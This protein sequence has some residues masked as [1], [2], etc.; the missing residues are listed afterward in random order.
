MPVHDDISQTNK[1]TPADSAQ[2]F[3]DLTPHRP[4]WL[5]SVMVPGLV[6]RLVLGMLLLNLLVVTLALWSVRQ[7]L[8]SQQAQAALE[9]G[10]LARLLDH[11]IVSS[12]HAID[13]ALQA[14]AMEVERQLAAGRLDPQAINRYIARQ[15][16][17]HPDLDGL[18]MSDAQGVLTHGTGVPDGRGPSIAD[19]GYFVRLK[20]EPAAGLVVTPPIQGRVSG[21][22]VLGLA[23]S[24]RRPDGSF[25][26]V[27]VGAVPLTRFTRAFAELSVGSGGSFTLFDD[28]LRIIIRFQQE[29]TAQ[30]L[31]GL[32]FGSP[33]LQELMRQGAQEGS[34]HAIGTV[35]GVERMFSFRK[36]QKGLNISVGRA[37]DDY[38]E[39]WRG[40]TL[41]TVARL[42]AFMLLSASMAWFVYRAWARQ[43]LA[44]QAL[45]EANRTLD[46]EKQLTQTIIQSSP[47]AI[48]ARDRRGIVTAWNGAAEKLFG[49]RAEEIVGRPLLSVPPDKLHET[50]ALRERVLRGESII[51]LEVRRLKKDGTLF[52]QS[53]TLAPLR[54]AD[55]KID[56]YLAIGADISERKAAEK[57]IEFLAYRDVLTGLPNR[58]LL[59][60]RFSQAVS[61]AERQQGKVGLLFLD[62][63]NF[64]TINDSLG[65]AVGDGLLKEIARRLGECVRESDTISRQG[66]D[67]FLIVLPDLRSADDISPVLIKIRERLQA[68][69]ELDGHELS[70]SASIGVALYP[71]DGRDFDTLLKKADTA[72][73]QAK[74]EGR[75]SYRFFDEQ[76]NVKAVEHL[77]LRNGLRRAIDR[78]EFELH[79]QPQL[80]LRTGAVIGAEALLRWRHPEQG[81]IPPGRFVPVAEDT[82]LI[83]PV[84]EWVLQE[85]CRQA[86]AWQGAGLPPLVMAV[87]LS[88]VQFRR[89]DIDQTV[90]RALEMSGLDAHFL[91]LELTESLLLQNT[92]QVLATVQRL[93]RQGVKLAIDDFGTGYSSLSYLKRFDVDKLKIDQTFIRD[94]A[95]D[96]NDAAIIRAIIQMARSLKLRTIAEGVENAGMLAQL[97]LFECDEAQGY[98]F[99]RPM[100]APD[101]ADYLGEHLRRQQVG[102]GD[103]I[104]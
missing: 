82:G 60:D 45:R 9:T 32:K 94:L 62:L 99:A 81:L 7:N 86:A 100:P 3:A 57:Q 49:W 74:D 52:D 30:E 61:Q 80:D 97:R 73:Y 23:R 40:E 103:W 101:F 41:K 59:Q 48:Y 10:N 31:I 46:A 102:E 13:F 15:L 91:E 28:E 63:D 6:R 17:I 21:K 5:R 12:I 37:A 66:G 39:E 4:A 20:Q 27:L 78:G 29:R 95:H 98:H 8:L 92:D 76:M 43:E 55:G 70:T 56:G 36:I 87:N 89:G 58:L 54:N 25:A 2:A 68:S 22:W 11:E 84:G 88:S 33:P 18:R 1:Q 24:Y 65:H 35:D 96:E 67:E 71:D 90:S 44:V 34:Y 42:V 19:R 64:K 50:Q 77:Q 51:D 69:I 26:G 47:L 93:K 53:T 79:Y 14:T 85:A 72:M 104:I 38:L 83:V 16:A 75:N